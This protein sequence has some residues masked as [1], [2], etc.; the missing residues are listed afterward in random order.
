MPMSSNINTS[1]VLNL[2]QEESKG[3]DLKKEMGSSDIPILEEANEEEAKQMIQDDRLFFSNQRSID[4][5]NSIREK[6]EEERVRE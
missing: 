1:K 5:M 6:Q 3:F 2:S 4:R